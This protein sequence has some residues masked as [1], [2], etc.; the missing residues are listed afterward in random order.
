MRGVK[1]K[2]MELTIEQYNKALLWSKKH[3][4]HV[5]NVTKDIDKGYPPSNEDKNQPELW[6]PEHWLWFLLNC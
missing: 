5:S 2:I 6:K 3:K 1:V 4:E